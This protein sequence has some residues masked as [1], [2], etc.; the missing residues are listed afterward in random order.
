M[1]DL[2]LDHCKYGALT[3]ASVMSNPME[4]E[5]VKIVL[6]G[7]KRTMGK[8]LSQQKEPMTVDMAKQV[9]EFLGLGD[10]LLHK[11]SVVI[12]L[13]VFS[14]FLWISELIEI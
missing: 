2:V 13:L 4:N 11:R 5:F 10:S 7:A 14:G 6:E 9:V 8:P 12:C 3:S 1:N